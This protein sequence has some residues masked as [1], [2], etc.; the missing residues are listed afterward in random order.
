MIKVILVKKNG[1]INSV[2]SPAEDDM[3]VHGEIYGDCKAYIVPFEL[4]TSNIDSWYWDEEANIFMTN[5]PKRPGTYYRWIDN[6]WQADLPELFLEIRKHRNMRLAATDFTQLADATLPVGTTLEQWHTYREALRALPTN[7][8]EV[9][10]LDE[11][12]WPT[13]PA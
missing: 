2:C 5:K 11:V 3:Y 6:Q 8:S 9:T 13:V 12:I 7:N 10:S 4:N 1:E